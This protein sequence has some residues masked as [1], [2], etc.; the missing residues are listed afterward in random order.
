MSG[1]KPLT[2]TVG[3]REITLLSRTVY[4]LCTVPGID[5]SALILQTPI[6]RKFDGNDRY[7]VVDVSACS[8]SFASD[9]YELGDQYKTLKEAAAA[10]DPPK[11]P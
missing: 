9:Y 1:Q 3:V 5:L 6:E 11:T 8:L 7:V 2:P 4:I 10:Y